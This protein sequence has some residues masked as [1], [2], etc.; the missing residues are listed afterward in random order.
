MV[1][2]YD[3]DRRLEQAIV[4]CCLQHRLVDGGNLEVMVSGGTVQINGEVGSY[5]Q[6][7]AINRLVA[8]SP[9]VRRVV[10]RL[11]VVPA[12]P[13]GDAALANRVEQAI[14]GESGVEGRAISVAAR[15]GHVELK[16]TVATA[17]ARLD[18]E[19]A[20]WHVPGVAEV[21]NKV[22]VGTGHVVEEREL[23]RRLEEALH[24]CLEVEPWR[25]SIQV[26]KGVAHLSGCVPSREYAREAEDLVRWHPEISDVIN[27]LTIEESAPARAE[28]LTA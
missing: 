20:A 25:I 13:V 23:S 24:W 28:G 9:G 26:D 12:A 22:H 3:D 11:R 18:A 17:S 4:N 19:Y 1:S 8:A 21:T 7:K 6:K 27:R 15:G 2:E 5:Q 10:N 16:G 14:L